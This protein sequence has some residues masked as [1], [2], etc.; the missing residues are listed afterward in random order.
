MTDPREDRGGNSAAPKI[1]KP[2]QVQNQLNKIVWEYGGDPANTDLLTALD[3]AG[4]NPNEI[5]PKQWKDATAAARNRLYNEQEGKEL[6]WNLSPKLENWCTSN[7]LIWQTVCGRYRVLKFP[8]ENKPPEYGA[9]HGSTRDR[10]S[11]EQSP[12]GPGYVKYYP[13]LRAA[14]EAVVKFHTE[15]FC[16]RSVGGNT[17]SLISMGE[18]QKIQNF[19]VP[20]V[21]SVDKIS[22]EP[23]NSETVLEEKPVATET[24]VETLTL[25]EASVRNMFVA[26][27]ETDAVNWSQKKLTKMLAD[28]ENILSLVEDSDLKDGTKERRTLSAVL[29]AFNEGAAITIE[30]EFD[31]AAEVPGVVPE[32]APEEET[33]ATNGHS[34]DPPKRRG[35]PKGSK[36]KPKDGE[37]PAP[38]AE[39]PKAETPAAEP[40]PKNKPGRPKKN[41][42]AAVPTPVT[43]AIAP[44]PE[45]VPVSTKDDFSPICSNT[46][47]VR[48][49]DAPI[50]TANST[51]EMVER[52]VQRA[53]VD[54]IVWIEIRKKSNLSA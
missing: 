44:E 4:I 37:T 47:V 2:H 23:E 54:S 16:L 5:T 43:A 8:R 24:E 18:S 39:K 25:K 38:K 9:D 21:P 17:D 6:H 30:F 11:I 31:G 52:L 33:H 7:V 46:E 27:G 1:L 10:R 12:A 19:P 15:K 36:N 35:R 53:D 49:P 3:R 45:A 42:E 41:P 32:A 26:L 40:A 22:G 13:S 14:V 20:E 28:H 29:E 51:Q 34:E 50:R 48:L